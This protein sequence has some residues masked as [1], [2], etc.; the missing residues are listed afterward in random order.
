MAI[1]KSSKQIVM[2]FSAPPSLDDIEALAL[3]ILENAPKELE[4]CIDD[5]EVI[6]DDFPDN[7]L[8]NDLDIEDDFEL[9][10]HHSANV[11]NGMVKRKKNDE[12]ILHLYRRPILDA[13][14]ETQESLDDLLAQIIISELCQSLDIHEDRVEDMIASVQS[15]DY[16]QAS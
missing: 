5:I 4:E 13:W 3:N 8:M 2:H 11:K 10:A 14:C 9:L 16:A 15:V 12:N 7:T 1:Q 6:V